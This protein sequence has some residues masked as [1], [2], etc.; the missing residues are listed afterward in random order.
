MFINENWKEFILKHG[1]IIEDDVIKQ[2]S[3]KPEEL[4]N[5]KSG[6]IITDLSHYGLISVDG[7]DA[8]SFLQ[9]QFSNDVR[10]VTETH[11]QLSAYCSPKGRMLAGF[12]VFKRGNTFYL[13]LPA[14]ILQSTL[15]RL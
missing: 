8:E 2:F 1:A 3:D 12:Q 15:K 14:S 6:N 10:L 5:A 4:T 11:S 9:N 7:E 13:R